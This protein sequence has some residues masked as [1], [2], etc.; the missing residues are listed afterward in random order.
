MTN[1]EMLFRLLFNNQET[2]DQ[3]VYHFGRDMA[4]RLLR[5]GREPFTTWAH[6]IEGPLAVLGTEIGEGDT[7]LQHQKTQT[8]NADTFLKNFYDGLESDELAIAAAL[9][10]WKSN[11]YQEFFP[12]NGISEYKDAPKKDLPRLFDRLKTT[13]EKYRAQL[14]AE[15][16]D[17]YIGYPGT[18]DSLAE[19]TSQSRKDRKENLNDADSARVQVLIA[20]HR[21]V[22]GVAME[23][24]GNVERCKEFVNLALLDPAHRAAPAADAPGA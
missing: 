11:G 14:P 23:Y 9:G 20:C 1:Y 21:A 8:R 5:A 7:S 10:G 18:W 19:K 4:H 22:H 16:A 6:A 2:P 3:N 17:R 13:A 15:L 12:R 24:P